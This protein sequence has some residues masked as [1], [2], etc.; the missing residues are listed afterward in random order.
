MLGLLC[1]RAV[2]VSGLLLY[3]YTLMSSWLSGTGD[4]R[5]RL[6]F[7]FLLWFT[8]TR[9]KSVVVCALLVALRFAGAGN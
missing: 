2:P 6:G 9:T 3:S 1:E 8:G 4:A 5:V 7:F